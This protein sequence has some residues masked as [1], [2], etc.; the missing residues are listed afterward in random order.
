M[1]VLK[2]TKGAIIRDGI[3]GKTI[4]EELEIQTTEKWARSRKKF[5]EGPRR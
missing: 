4:R 5:L 3:R 2:A 1:G